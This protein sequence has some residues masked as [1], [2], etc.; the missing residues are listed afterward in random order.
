MSDVMRFIDR[1]DAGQR[2]GLELTRHTVDRPLLVLGL[3]RGGVPVAARVA[4]ELNAPLDVFI[5]RKLGV[6]GHEEL[7]FGAIASGGAGVLNRGIINDLGIRSETIERVTAREK[8][9]LERRET[10]YRGHQPFPVIVGETIVVVDDGAA[11]GASIRAAIVALRDLGPR[12][13]IAAIP[14]ASREAIGLIEAVADHCYCL[15]APEPFLGV[16]Y[17]YEDFS[18]TPDAEVRILLSEARR[19]WAVPRV[20]VHS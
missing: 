8:V 3:P 13:I 5:V 15:F 18:E 20:G 2:L 4:A 9:E 10:A 7:A 11:T 16:G 19:R 14:V 17:W 12:S 6:P 1:Y